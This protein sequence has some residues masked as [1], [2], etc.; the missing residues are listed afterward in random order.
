MKHLVT[1]IEILK[2]GNQIWAS[3]YTISGLIYSIY[4]YFKKRMDDKKKN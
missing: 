1:M 2:S 3:A 4:I